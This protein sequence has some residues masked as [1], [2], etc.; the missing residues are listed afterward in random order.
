MRASFNPALASGACWVDEVGRGLEVAFLDSIG[1][2]TDRSQ[3][4][5]TG[6]HPFYHPAVMA[7]PWHHHA[8]ADTQS[9]H[10]KG[11]YE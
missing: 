3:L 7:S 8:R 6:L 1:S 2:A 9:R 5:I 10:R 4:H 11:K